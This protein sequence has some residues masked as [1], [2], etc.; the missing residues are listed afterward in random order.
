MSTDLALSTSAALWLSLF[1]LLAN[2]FF[3]GAE[4]AVMSVRRSQ[5]EPLVERKVPGAATALYA[6]EHVSQMLT[7]AQ[8]GVTVCTTSLGVLA[9]PALAHLLEGP[10]MAIGLPAVAAHV[11]AVAISV[12]FVVYLHVVAGE[13]IPKNLAI[14]VPDRAALWFGPPLVWISKILMPVIWLLTSLS[15]LA[16][17]ALGIEPRDEVASAFTASEVASI[18]ELS[19]AEGVLRD[20]VGL[21]AGAIDFSEETARAVM[22]TRDRVHA[23]PVAVTPEQLERE[24]ARTGFSRFPVE[25]G[26]EL[27]GYL[28]IKDVLYADEHTRTRAVPK[29]RIRP[30]VAIA[31]EDEVEESLRAMQRSGTHLAAVMEDGNLVGVVFLEDILEELVGEVRDSVQRQ[32]NQNRGSLR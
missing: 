27:I 24:V 28:H 13:M 4:F 19:Q 15:N 1:L 30:L 8:I 32:K 23:V 9:E 16:L 21:L 22:V 14:A 7:T 31:P 2:A 3:V 29:W 10:L 11:V 18:V 6:V 25:D 20:D 5:L 17:R 12:A 26:G